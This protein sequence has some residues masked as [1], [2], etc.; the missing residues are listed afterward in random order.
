MKAILVDRL[1]P[2]QP[3]I[4]LLPQ[5]IWAC[6]KKRGLATE[7]LLKRHEGRSLVG[8]ARQLLPPSTKG[9]E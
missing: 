8:M 7:R 3:I 6:S 9:H 2:L 4:E 5:E 1:I